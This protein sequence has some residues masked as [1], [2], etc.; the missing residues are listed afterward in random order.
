M[1]RSSRDPPPEGSG[2]RRCLRPS[3]RAPGSFITRVH[4]A[5]SLLTKPL[6]SSGVPPI[7]TSLPSHRAGEV[8]LAAIAA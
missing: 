5:V 1:A 4:F 3:I 6:S 2:W 7:T 8:G